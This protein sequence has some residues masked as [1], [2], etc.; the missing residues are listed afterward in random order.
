MKFRMWVRS[1]RVPDDVVKVVLPMPPDFRYSFSGSALPF[2]SEN[3]A[4]DPA[5][6]PIYVHPNAHTLMLPRSTRTPNFYYL[7][8]VY[9][10]PR[11]LL[12]YTSSGQR[13]QEFQTIHGVNPVPGRTLTPAP[14]ILASTRPAPVVTQEALIRGNAMPWVKCLGS[15]AL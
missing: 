8:G 13:V 11:A 12:E 15:H 9:S 1:S 2:S 4:F 7:N 3:A 6:P 10:A 5:Q 14:R